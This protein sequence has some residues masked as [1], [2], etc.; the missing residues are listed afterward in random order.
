MNTTF[1]PKITLFHCINTLIDKSALPETESDA[2]ELK[3]VKLPCSAMV[4]DIFLLRAFEAG[5]DGV[6]VI[7]CPEGTCRYV[8]GNI[9]A[10]KRVTWVKKLLDEIGVGG[11][12]LALHNIPHGDIAEAVKIINQTVEQ[13]IESGPNP[14]S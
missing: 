10:Q 12:R 5:A 14:A 6:A 1:K 3:V 8:E 9:R 4:K 13:L 11:D 7:V 2:F